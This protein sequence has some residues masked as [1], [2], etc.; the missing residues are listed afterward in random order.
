MMGNPDEN[1]HN[2]K[3]NAL[4]YEAYP[5]T[6]HDAKLRNI[7]FTIRKFQDFSFVESRIVA[8]SLL[9][10]N[11]NNNTKDKQLVNKRFEARTRTLIRSSIGAG[12][13]PT[14]YTDWLTDS[15]VSIHWAP[16]NQPTQRPLLL[17]LSFQLHSLL[18][19][20]P[21]PPSTT[22][23]VLFFSLLFSRRLTH[24]L[25]L[26]SISTVHTAGRL[27]VAF[28]TTTFL[29]LYTPSSETQVRT[30]LLES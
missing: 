25:I 19:S 10:F 11:N 3:N 1:R 2:H 30:F 14:E 9:L 7:S 15:A 4:N 16:S 12:A 8:K 23:F 20:S 21:P 17:S 22:F 18:L 27:L 29:L 13:E 24:S 26:F 5:T 28:A 6:K